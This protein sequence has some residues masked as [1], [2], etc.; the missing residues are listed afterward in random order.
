MVLREEPPLR[1]YL[2]SIGVRNC[3]WLDDNGRLHAAMKA[4][5]IR[6]CPSLIE[7][8]GICIA[9][10]QTDRGPGIIVCG[11]GVRCAVHV[12][13]FY[14]RT[15]F[16]GNRNRIEGETSDLDFDRVAADSA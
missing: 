13:P 8:M 5:M 15:N 6:V 9:L 4:A 2:N 16:D 12:D 7:G 14:G 10:F 11:D 3:S 1:P